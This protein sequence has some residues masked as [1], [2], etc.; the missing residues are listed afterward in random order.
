M[1]C[2]SASVTRTTVLLLIC[3]IA[4]VWK[5][6]L[7]AH[8][9]CRDGRRRPN[10]KYLANTIRNTVNYNVILARREAES[11]ARD[12]CRDSRRRHRSRREERRT[13]T[14]HRRSGGSESRR[15]EARTTDGIR[16]GAERKVTRES[17]RGRRRARRQEVS[18]TPSSSGEQD[19]IPSP[20]LSRKYGGRKTISK[21]LVGERGDTAVLLKDEKV[22]TSRGKVSGVHDELHGVAGTWGR[23]SR[24]G[25][26]RC[27]HLGVHRPPSQR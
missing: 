2:E 1:L 6:K 7:K 24:N 21:E 22:T 12:S 4:A 11:A 17:S 23:W 20:F 13:H 9:W 8:G 27:R 25:C 26:N 18:N 16:H 3:G 10:S 14:G 15:P 19:R 5:H